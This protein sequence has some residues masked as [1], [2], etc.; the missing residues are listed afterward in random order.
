MTT[1]VNKDGI[2]FDID[3]ILTDLNNK[4]DVDLIN[5]STTGLNL[6]SVSSLPSDNGEE[7]ILGA[8]GTQYAAPANGWVCVG[9]TSTA[10]GQILQLASTWM[11]VM[12][13]SSAAD[14]SWRIV[15]PIRRGKLFRLNYSMNVT[16]LQFGYAVGLES[17]A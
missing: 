15:L 7:I 3:D 2:E 16:F 17:E 4:A 9:G 1:F 10:S 14:Q 11:N 12:V 6:M 8:S 13:S 5:V